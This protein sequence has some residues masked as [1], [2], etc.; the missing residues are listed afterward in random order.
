MMKFRYLFYFL[1][2]T[3]ALSGQENPKFKKKEFF[4]DTTNVKQVKKDYKKAQKYY[5]KGPGTFDEALKSYSKVYRYNS[6]NVALNYKLGICCLWTSDKKRALKYFKESDPSVAKD[7]YLAL[8]RAYQ[9]NFEYDNAKQAYNDYMNSLKKWRQREEQKKID[10]LLAECDFSQQLMKKDSLP[11]YI[12]NMGPLI[13]SYYDDYGAILPKNDTVIYFTSKRPER[14]PKKRVSRFKF[15]EQLLISKNCLYEPAQWVIEDNKFSSGKNV[16][17]AG[18]DYQNNRL[19][20]YK[21]KRQNGSIRVSEYNAKRNEWRKPKKLWGLNEVAYKE[22][23]IAIDN[24]GNCYYITNKRG[25][26]GGKDIWYVQLDEDGQIKTKPVNMGDKI[27]T[28]FDEASVYISEDGL[29][30]YFA[31]NGRLGMGG[32]DIYK[33]DRNNPMG[34]WGE[35]ENLGHP[36]NSPADE[37]FYY[38]TQDPLYAIYS[39]IREGGYG[40]LDIYKIETDPR[41]PFKL[42][43]TVEDIETGKILPANITVY[44]DE[45]NQVA[46]TT[47]VDEASGMYMVNFEDIGEFTVEAQYPEYRGVTQKL[48][49]PSEKHATTMLDFKMEMLKHPFTLVGKV[50]DIDSGEPLQATL[51]FKMAHADSLLA[52]TASIDSTGAY[53]VTFEDK[54]DM[55]A[56]VS[57]QDYFAENAAISVLGTKDKVIEKDFA[58]KRSKIDYV[59]TGRIYEEE[60]EKSIMGALSFYRPGDESPFN[61][62]I[63]DSISGKYN[64]VLPDQGPFVLE[65][66]ATRYFFQNEA[67]KFSEGE[68]LLM[69]NFIMKPMKQG[70]KFVV[71]NILFNSGKA[72][73]KAE[74][75]KELDKLAILLIKNEEVRIEVSGHTDNVGSSALNK[76][77]SKQRAL[78]VKNYLVS[79]GVEDS[80][81]EYEGYGFDQPIAPNDTPDGR[82]QNRRVEVKILN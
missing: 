38:P 64:A 55:V 71:E 46:H 80:R 7:Y 31:S 14:E 3:V 69:K 63:S 32:F 1:L 65:V 73:L 13:N 60:T 34:D 35:P 24:N 36:V 17:L 23:Q 74:S 19:Y 33:T 62:V 41:R 6:S 40:G 59:L 77:L 37:L 66:D 4:A 76:K 27:N 72:T 78:T 47:V 75:F 51:L 26:E 43:G 58:L 16:G 70:V 25:G 82:A 52:R 81:I 5:K 20:M 67:F 29:T 22:T 21:G 11:V 39:T 2:I 79:R 18:Y 42:I 44:D 48:T 15:D 9:Y 68:T 57:A 54:F 61:I 45:K 12:K 8:G 10:Q 30:M 50:T 49:C 56:E 53:S 28:K